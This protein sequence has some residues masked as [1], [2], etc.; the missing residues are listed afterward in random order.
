LFRLQTAI[1]SAQ[2]VMEQSA[3]YL[4]YQNDYSSDK[5]LL[6]SHIQFKKFDILPTRELIS[7]IGQQQTIKYFYFNIFFL[8]NNFILE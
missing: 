5:D 2:N 8:I 1:T 3:S 6:L 4:L 7:L